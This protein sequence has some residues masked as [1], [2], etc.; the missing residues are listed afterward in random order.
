M[1]GAVL[2]GGGTTAPPP[3]LL[4][5][6]V[7]TTTGTTV[8]V[9][10]DGSTVP[11]QAV[12][13]A[14]YQWQLCLAPY[15]PTPGA[16]DPAIGA[17]VMGMRVGSTFYISHIISGG[18]GKTLV[19]YCAVDGTGGQSIASSGSPGVHLTA[20][21]GTAD[22]YDVTWDVAN[23]QATIATAGRYD[24][25]A[26][27]SFPANATGQRTIAVFKNGAQFTG[28]GA[29]M[30]AAN[31]VNSLGTFFTDNLRFAVGDT[32]YISGSQNSG[33]ALTNNATKLKIKWTG[34]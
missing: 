31:T 3:M 9:L 7:A 11:V 30:S 1:S 4:G 18:R 2:L 6:V 25:F 33:A 27:V 13:P 28:S 19:P 16:I 32:I 26:M 15:A 23:T 21:W 20:G 17:R 34:P 14:N 24:L 12:V 10:L 29:Q 22:T 5:T 8:S